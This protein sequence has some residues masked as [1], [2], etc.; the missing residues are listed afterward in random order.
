MFN[1][2]ERRKSFDKAYFKVLSFVLDYGG[3]AASIVSGASSTTQNSYLVGGGLITSM[4]TPLTDKL[5]VSGEEVTRLRSSSH[6]DR[7]ETVLDQYTNGQIIR[8]LFAW[9]TAQ[10]AVNTYNELSGI[11]LL[12]TAGF[13][14]L[15]AINGVFS[16]RSRKKLTEIV[17]SK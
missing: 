12:T 16:R 5:F 11:N 14:T 2:L 15:A 7:A 8:N 9:F 17:E 6:N 1:L 10:Q 13:A 4:A 3:L